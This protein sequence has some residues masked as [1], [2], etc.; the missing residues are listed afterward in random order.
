MVPDGAWLLAGLSPFGPP[1]R[2][3]GLTPRAAAAEAR[4]GDRAEADEREAALEQQRGRRRTTRG[5]RRED[6]KKRRRERRS[7]RERASGSGPSSRRSG[8]TSA[9]SRAPRP[10]TRD[11]GTAPWRRST[12]CAASTARAAT[13]PSTGRPT[14]QGRLGR[15]TEAQATLAE[16][17]K[18]H[19]QSR[20]LSEAKALEQ[21]LSQASGKPASPASAD[22]EEIKLLAL[23]SLMNS[24]SEQAPA[25]ARRLP[26]DQA[27][28][29]AAGPRP[30]R[31]QPERLARAPARSSSASPGA[32]RAPTSRRG[33]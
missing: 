23:N 20:W 33:R 16:L 9:T 31:A 13:A 28:A 4:G 3:G 32:P 26:E 27:L 8:P 21:E 12:R 25:P 30:L 15:R 1:A 24:D 22:D 19:P 14:R 6:E 2:P 17:R 5:A 11:A 18:S 10:S 7:A 29:P